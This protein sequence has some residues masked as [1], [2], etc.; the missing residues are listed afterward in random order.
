MVAASGRVANA[1]FLIYVADASGYAGSIA[2][3]LWRNFGVAHMEWLTVFRLAI[4]ATTIVG[5]VLVTLSLF[6]F[7]GRARNAAVPASA[8]A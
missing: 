8:T 7:M 3:L 5:L 4:Y 6:Y 2:L 1:G